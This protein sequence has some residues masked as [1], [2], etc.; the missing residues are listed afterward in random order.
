M[1]AADRR[2]R[3]RTPGTDGTPAVGA[4][5]ALV[6]ALA[7]TPTRARSTAHLITHPARAY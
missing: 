1:E 4:R 3:R 2:T 6:L 5:L 7:L